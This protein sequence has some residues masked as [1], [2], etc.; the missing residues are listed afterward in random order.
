V[1]RAASGADFQAKLADGT[2][3]DVSLAG[4][5]TL[6]DVISAINRAD[7]TKLKAELT[8]AGGLR[9]TDLNHRRRYL[10]PDRDE[11][12]TGPDRPWL[13]GR[14]AVGQVSNGAKFSAPSATRAT[15][16]AASGYAFESRI[17]ALIDP[18]S[19]V[20]PR[21]NKQLDDKAAQFQDRIDSMDKLLTPSGNASSGSSRTWN[22]SLAAPVQQARSANSDDPGPSRN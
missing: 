1:R 3:L 15:A 4:A 18:V 8:A 14:K 9:V 13:S 2:T 17:N 12:V 19:G 11:R 20:I 7:N 5:D 10:R 22:R 21:E 16:A 6:G